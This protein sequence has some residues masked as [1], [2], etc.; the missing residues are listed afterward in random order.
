[1]DPVVSNTQVSEILL[2]AGSPKE[3]TPH[4]LVQLI[5]ATV[6]SSMLPQINKIDLRLVNLEAR[7]R[8]IEGKVAV[9]EQQRAL[10]QNLQADC[11]RLKEDNDTLRKDLQRATRL[12]L[13]NK[14]HSF[15]Y[16]L[17]LH[18]VSEEHPILRG[19][20]D[21]RHPNFRDAILSELRQF[22]ATVN[23][24]DFE[25]AHRLG[26]PKTAAANASGAPPRAILIKFYSRDLKQKLLDE[27]IRRYKTLKNTARSAPAT[28]SR[29]YLTTHRV[30]ETFAA[31]DDHE[32]I[33]PCME[34]AIPRERTLRK[35]NG[36]QK[37]PL[38]G[39]TSR[40]RRLP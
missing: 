34:K 2:S 37:S 4:T 7:A 14:R 6:N 28:L 24:R 12:A 38:Q 40:R 36:N 9:F 8:D 17:L 20:A 23:D 19:A 26:P 3:L 5:V 31:D 21:A 11:K 18:G 32:A 16:N 33:E 39:T 29:P 1:M 25:R 13:D 15:Q 22:D 10:I 35:R 30:R 27:S